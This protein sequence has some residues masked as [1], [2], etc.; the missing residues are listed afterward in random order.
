MKARRFSKLAFAT[1]GIILLMAA[2][3]V[4][5]HGSNSAPMPDFTTGDKIPA[6]YDHDWNLGPTGA[7][8]WIYCDG[9]ETTKARQI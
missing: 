8:G 5:Q 6:G 4:A 3:V 2:N 7:R 1:S 9:F